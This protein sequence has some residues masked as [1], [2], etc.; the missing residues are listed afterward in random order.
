M[1]PNDNQAPSGA[2]RQGGGA[3][4][5]QG[6]TPGADGNG[7]P[8]GNQPVTM[9]DL[10]ALKGEIKGNLSQTYQ[11]IQGLLDR[12]SGNLRAAVEPVNRVLQAL[13][14]QGIEV[15]E[16]TKAAIR[17]STLDEALLG[18]GAGGNAQ[19]GQQPGQGGQP[20]AEDGSQVGALQSLALRMFQ[21]RGM[22]ILANDPELALVDQETQ[23][24]QVFMGSVDKA[25]SSKA[26]R[27]AKGQLAEMGVELPE[28][29]DHG[30]DAEPSAPGPG[31]N[32]RGKGR[33][34]PNLLPEQ[35]P[36]GRN[37]TPEDR[38]RVGFE[39]ETRF[40]K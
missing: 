10:E 7:Q 29:D 30:N 18:D 2:T 33:K 23:D 35:M 27:L 5:D 22:A 8:D 21:E 34:Q 28:T 14:A 32:L 16:A 17:S 15:P 40:S 13:E 36:S 4:A 26:L 38:L 11:G 39:Q 24:P 6:R 19:P 1:P 12:Q 31:M 3:S 9:A 20:G 37:T 25:L